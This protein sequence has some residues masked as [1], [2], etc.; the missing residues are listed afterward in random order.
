MQRASEA[1]STRIWA[2]LG[3]SERRQLN[4]ALRRLARGLTF[5]ATR[6]SFARG[7][8]RWPLFRLVA[9]PA[10]FLAS[11]PYIALRGFADDTGLPRQRVALGIDRALGFGVTPSERLQ[12]WFFSGELSTFDWFWLLVHM[13]W[14]FVPGAITGY[15][16]IFRWPL[17]RSLVSVR[18]GVLYVAALCFLLLPTEPP[19]M[20]TDV[21]RLLDLKAGTVLNVDTNPVAALPSLHVALPA[22]LAIW[23]RAVGMRRWGLFFAVHT[24]LTAFDVVYLGEHMVVDVVAGIALAAVVV[25]WLTRNFDP[26][27]HEP[28]RLAQ[29]TPVNSGSPTN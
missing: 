3:P 26:T 13:S 14:F 7:F 1:G 10:L 17:F 22:A 9:W 4:L 15:V 12:D 25:W 29:K 20:T 18:L 16:L 28:P 24:G 5:P 11:L 8:E 19:W 6:A 23:A 2:R 21:T 27:S